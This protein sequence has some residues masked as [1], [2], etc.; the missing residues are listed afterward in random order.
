M[1]NE[2]QGGSSHHFIMNTSNDERKQQDRQ[3]PP[4]TNTERAPIMRQVSTTTTTTTKKP[5]WQIVRDMSMNM[6]SRQGTKLS[7]KQGSTT[8]LISQ[9]FLTKKH[10]LHGASNVPK[11]VQLYQTPRMPT[12]KEAI[13]VAIAYEL[14]CSSCGGPCIGNYLRCRVCT[15]TYHSQCLFERGYVNDQSFYLP[16]LAKQDWSCP[17]CSDLTQLLHQDELD[18]L[19]QAFEQIDTNKDGYII[20]EEYLSLKSNKI[21][22]NDLE[23]FIQHNHDLGKKYFSLMDSTQQGV[24]CWSDFALFYS[25]KLIAAKDKFELTRKLTEKE[26]VMAKNLFFKDLRKTFD[27]DGKII[28]TRDHLK[29]V[30]HDLILILEK[31]YGIEFIDTIL[32]Y[33]ESIEDMSKKHSV[34]NW[35]E[36]LSEIALL[37]LLNRSN[38]NIKRNQ[39]RR[40]TIPPHLSNASVVSRPEVSSTGIDSP[41]RVTLSRLDSTL[42]TPMLPNI[43]CDESFRKH[44]KILE[45]L[46]KQNQQEELIRK[47]MGASMNFTIV[48]NLD[49]EENINLPKLKLNARDDRR[50]ITDPWTSVKEIQQLRNKPV[51]VKTTRINVI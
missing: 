51:L 21:K 12:E 10:S 38:D 47:K 20:L 3:S 15:K 7:Y 16:R 25:C 46:N 27:N 48:E 33:D 23:L 9:R 8:N 14:L 4:W 45:K 30:H 43:S 17:E 13:Q 44:A 22:S 31:K 24:V 28:I 11:P 5:G 50:A 18:N 2:Q 49:E 40:A 1:G 39:S 42:G 19:I 6:L 36:F 32:G 34:M 29:Q 26:L 35:G 41:S 37:I